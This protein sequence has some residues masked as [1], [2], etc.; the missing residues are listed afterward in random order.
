MEI[1]AALIITALRTF[2]TEIDAEMVMVA[3][4]YLGELLK[5]QI[6]GFFNYH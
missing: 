4:E 1:D 2:A 3:I 6:I 5:R